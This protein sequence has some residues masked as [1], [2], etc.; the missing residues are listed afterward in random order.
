MKLVKEITILNKRAYFTVPSI[1]LSKP[2]LSLE[3][4]TDIALCAIELVVGSV[5]NGTCRCKTR[6]Q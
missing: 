1:V 4:L 6:T 2:P 5:F 3:V